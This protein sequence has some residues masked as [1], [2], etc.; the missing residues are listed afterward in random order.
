MGPFEMLASIAA[1]V[2]ILA[3]DT[4]RA[5]ARQ[6]ILRQKDVAD[7]KGNK[8]MTPLPACF[9]IHCPPPSPAQSASSSV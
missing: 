9:I 4:R 7:I 8:L 6:P 5:S 3:Q 1:G 2:S